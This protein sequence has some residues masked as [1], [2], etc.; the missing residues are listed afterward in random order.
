MWNV[1]L[2][3]G[4]DWNQ[5]TVEDNYEQR[6]ISENPE[7]GHLLGIEIMYTMTRVGYMDGAKDSA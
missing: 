4:I 5:A 1:N 7:L 2:Q 3:W 6:K